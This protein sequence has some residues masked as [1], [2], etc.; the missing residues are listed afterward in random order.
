MNYHHL[1]VFT[2]T[3]VANLQIKDGGHYL[4]C[5][6]GGGGHSLAILQ[7]GNDIHLTAIDQ[8][9]EALTATK[10]RL[11]NYQ[12]QV[13][14]WH[15][16]F[17]DFPPSHTQRFDGII[18]DLGVSSHQIDR[19]ERGFSFRLSAPLDMRMNPSQSLTCADIINHWSEVDLANLIYKYGE[20]RLSRRIARQIVH[21]RPLSTTTAL[22]ELIWQA[23][24]PSYRHGPIHPA[25]RSFQAL[26]IAVNGELDHLQKWLE[27]SPD[28]LKPNGRIAVISFHSLED[29]II[30]H[31]FREDS[32]L[33]VITK[34]P[35][36]P[37]TAEIATNPRAR[38]AKL[39]V[40]QKIPLDALID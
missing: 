15:G 2:E 40:A 1:S 22:A 38:S 23:V 20:E 18:A 37:D 9:Q 30:K 28:W 33:Q 7:A 6:C 5:T 31:K 8:D 25:T 14:L 26:R 10:E 3:L 12:E 24:P 29:R 21:S 34:K 32:R 16:N 27:Q 17:S 36:V 19:P 39:R 13:H 11:S 35:I 4:D